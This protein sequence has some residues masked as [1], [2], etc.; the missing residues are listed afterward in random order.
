M[1]RFVIALALGIFAIADIINGLLFGIDSNYIEGCYHL[2][3]GCVL[4]TISVAL[5]KD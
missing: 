2:L 3:R 5:A 4:G 1:F